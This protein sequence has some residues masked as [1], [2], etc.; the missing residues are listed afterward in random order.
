MQVFHSFYLTFCGMKSSL[1]VIDRHRQDH[2]E[3]YHHPALPAFTFESII[4]ITRQMVWAWMMPDADDHSLGDYDHYFLNQG[5]PPDP[6]DMLAPLD[7]AALF[8]DRMD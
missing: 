7:H 3:L 6:E 8:E 4:T 2:P 5:P 1:L